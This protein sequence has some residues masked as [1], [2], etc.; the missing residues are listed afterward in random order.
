MGIEITVTDH[1][2]HDAEADHCSPLCICSCCAAT[3][4]L[5]EAGVCIPLHVEH[6]TSP[7]TLYIQQALHQN[8]KPIW[9]PP[10]VS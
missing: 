8:A 9:Q 10:K 2:H 1:Q 4:Q 3:V 6:N 5:T 7:V